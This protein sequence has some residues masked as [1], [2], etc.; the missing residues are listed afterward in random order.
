MGHPHIGEIAIPL[1][2]FSPGFRRF[3]KLGVFLGQP[4]LKELLPVEV[5]GEQNR[6]NQ[7]AEQGQ[8]NERDQGRG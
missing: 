5:A 6:G 7:G 2:G 1:S 8:D 3:R 4:A